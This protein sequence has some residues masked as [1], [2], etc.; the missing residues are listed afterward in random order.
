MPID[1]RL[2]DGLERS[3]STIDTDVEPFL[4]DAR[5]RGRRR[6][7]IRRAVTVVT[8]AAAIALVAVAGPSLRDLF[9]GREQQPAAP[10]PLVQL[11]GTYTTTIR[12]SD[13]T[14]GGAG[15][16]GKWL[17]TLDRNG[18][19]DLASLTN[20]EQ[21]SLGDPISGH[22]GRVPHDG[23]CRRPVLRPRDVYDGRG[24]GRSS[25]S[26]SSATH[27]RFASRSSPRNRGRCNE[28]SDRRARA[29]R[30]RMHGRLE[31]RRGGRLHPDVRADGVP[32]PR[33]GVRL[34]RDHVRL[35]DRARESVEPVGPAD[36]PVRRP[37][38]AQQA[39]DRPTRRLRGE[40]SGRTVRLLRSQ[41]DGRSPGWSGGH[42]ARTARHRFLRTQPV[43]PGGGC[44]LIRDDHGPDRRSRSA[45]GVRR[46]GDGLSRSIRR[47]GHRPLGVQRA[48]GRTRPAGP[49]RDAR[50]RGMGCRHQGLD[51]ARRGG[52]DAIEPAGLASPRGLQPRVPGARTVSSR[53]SRARGRRFRG[54]R[55]FATPIRPALGG[56]PTSRRRS[57][58][59]SAGSTTIPAR[60]DSE[61][62]TSRST[63]LACSATCATSWHRSTPG[64]TDVPAPPRH[65][66]RPRTREGPDRRDHGGRLTGAHR[67]D[68][69]H[70]LCAGLRPADESGRV[71]LGAV[72]RYRAIHRRRGSRVAGGKRGGVDAGLR[73]RSVQRRLRSV[74]GGTG[75]RCG[76]RGPASRTCRC[77][78][79]AEGSIRPC[80][81]MRSAAGSRDCRTPCTS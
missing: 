6:L 35:P 7:V 26:R 20:G 63:A 27:V 17:L 31:R 59:R 36:P 12:P 34:A 2:R 49:R 81:P 9:R 25:R 68:V 42:R 23:P 74:A 16:A 38:R 4:H 39:N 78:C 64:R 62:R 75:R 15:A 58:R 79:S 13:L 69:L 72:H 73:R 54:S 19:L 50:P 53:R 33:D 32:G 3:M 41:R 44:H 10:S 48:G 29:A 18:T 43:L 24:A 66:R 5:R 21:R 60:S 52:G 70:G 11:S 80:R 1:A 37:L 55:R 67:T 14:G 45:P 30:T 61:E 47:P 77:S 40:L 71:L 76:H 28:T 57:T 22:A 51:V 8:I 56:S 65:D 46:G